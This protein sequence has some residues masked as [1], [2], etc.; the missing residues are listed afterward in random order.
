VKSTLV[1]LGCRQSPG[2]VPQHAPN[3]LPRRI[4]RS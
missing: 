4:L 3:A 1:Y 2:D